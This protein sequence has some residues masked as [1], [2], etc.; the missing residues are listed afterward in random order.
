MT[1]K[2]YRVERKKGSFVKEEEENGQGEVP[3]RRII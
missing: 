2:G 3:P 1:R